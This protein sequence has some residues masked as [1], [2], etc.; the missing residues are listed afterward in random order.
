MKNETVGNVVLAALL[1]LMV[2][3]FVTDAHAQDDVRVCSNKTTYPEKIVIVCG[4]C[5]CPA[6]YY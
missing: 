3:I 2:T 6:G 5:Q 4:S 1:A